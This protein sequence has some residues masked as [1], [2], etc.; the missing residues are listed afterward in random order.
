[1][2]TLS[3]QRVSLYTVNC[4]LYNTRADFSRLNFLQLASKGLIFAITVKLIL[5]L[6]IQELKNVRAF[7]T[8]SDPSLQYLGVQPQLSCYLQILN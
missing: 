1:M 3:M 4:A 8:L 7:L 6:Y 2:L 5:N